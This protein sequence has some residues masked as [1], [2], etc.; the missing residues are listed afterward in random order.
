MTLDVDRPD[1]CV[2]RHN[3]PVADEC[4]GEEAGSNDEQVQDATDSSAGLRRELG[5]RYSAHRYIVAARPLR[6]NRNATKRGFGRTNGGR[7]HRLRQRFDTLN[8]GAD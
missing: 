8:R 6:E 7:T 4:L 1:R 2:A 5:G 3:K